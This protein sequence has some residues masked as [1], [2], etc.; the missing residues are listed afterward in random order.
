MINA[1]IIEDERPAARRL[2]KLLSNYDITLK[3]TLHSLAESQEWLD[4]NPDPEL[5]FLDIQLSDGLSFELF[6]NRKINSCIIFTTAYDEYALKAFK[7]NS[8]DYLLKPIDKKELKSA[9]EKY[10][11]QHQKQ[12]FDF[13][14]IRSLFE[15]NLQDKA[16]KER[17]TIK[18]GEHLKVFE[19]GEIDGFLSKHKTSYLLTKQGREYPL[20]KSLEEIDGLLSPK[21]FFR[22]NRAFI[23]HVNA[24]KDIISYSNSRLR[25]VLKHELDEPLIVSRERVKEFKAWLD[26]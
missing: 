24:I 19:V 4:S 7:V 18:V 21:Y 10:E 9:I 17:F 8:I 20:E 14:N 2:Q 1:I 12:E 22:I 3:A 25:I 23:L 6:K 15:E 5:I 16:Y 26:S 11:N 13:Q